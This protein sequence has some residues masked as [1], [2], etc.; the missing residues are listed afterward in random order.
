MEVTVKSIKRQK[1]LIYLLMFVQLC[2][3]G[4]GVV[5]CSKGDMGFGLF[6]ILVNSVSIPFNVRTIIR[7][8]KTQKEVAK[9]EK[10]LDNLIKPHSP[11]KI[12]NY[13]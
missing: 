5:Q 10:E 12:N 3:I 7:Y 1:R 11:N 4:V 6:N 9:W 8:N 2:L 13:G